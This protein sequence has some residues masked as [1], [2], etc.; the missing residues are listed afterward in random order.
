M[1]KIYL[2]A[3][4]VDIPPIWR[5]KIQDVK[6]WCRSDEELECYFPDENGVPNAWG[7]SM[8]E[9]ARCIF[10]MDVVAIDKADWV[11]VCDFGRKNT[12]GTSWEAGYAFG[13]DKKILIIYMNEDD[14]D[15]SVMLNGCSSNAVSFY[16]L[17]D[18]PIISSFLYER[19]KAANNNVKFN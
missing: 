12:A 13:K 19:G 14:D 11:I 17:A 9:W 7:M 3:P 2:A 6:R 4:I 16:D 1:I 8:N 5:K 15:Y 10:T 18:Q